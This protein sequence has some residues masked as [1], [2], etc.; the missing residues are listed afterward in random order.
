MLSFPVGAVAHDPST[1]T[2]ADWFNRQQMNEAA[3]KRLGVEYKSCCDAGDHFRTRFR[4]ASDNSDQ[5]QYFAKDGT[6]KVVPPDIIKEGPTP[7]DH[8]VLFINKYDGK[9]LCFFVPKGGI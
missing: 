1:H 3:R 6:W 7:E 4:V 8:P 5:W 2:H 9:E